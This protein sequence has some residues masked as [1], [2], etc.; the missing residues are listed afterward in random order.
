MEQCDRLA[1]ADDVDLMGEGFAGRDRQMENLR[2]AGKRIGLE[3]N[4]NKTKVMKMSRDE[5]HVQ[6][7]GCQLEV[8]N[9]FKYLGS[10]LTSDSDVSEEIKIR[11]GAASRASPIFSQEAPR[12]KRM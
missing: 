7:G 1:Y 12:S 10:T 3:V 9:N 6:A 11:I 5:D 2:N 8:V 4:E